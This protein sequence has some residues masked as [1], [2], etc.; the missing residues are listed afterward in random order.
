MYSYITVYIHIYIHIYIYIYK[1]DTKLHLSSAKN[2]MF[3]EGNC[4][5][6]VCK[7]L[8]LGLNPDFWVISNPFTSPL[9]IVY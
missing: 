5:C 6:S 3:M 4:H 9:C 2:P 1:N 7:K 8:V